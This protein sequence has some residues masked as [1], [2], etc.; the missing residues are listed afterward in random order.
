MLGGGT[1]FRGGGGGGWRG[2]RGGGGGG[3][4]KQMCVKQMVSA[5]L[6]WGA[7]WKLYMYLVGYLITQ[8]S[9]F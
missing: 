8:H 9:W 7:K 4:D 6:L 1:L 5:V 3:G 2:G